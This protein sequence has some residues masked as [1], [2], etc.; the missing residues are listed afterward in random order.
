MFIYFTRKDYSRDEKRPTHRAPARELEFEYVGGIRAKLSPLRCE[1]ICM[2][3]RGGSI[4][5][6]VD[7]SRG[8]LGGITALGFCISAASNGDGLASRSRRR[9][10]RRR[11]WWSAGA[12]ASTDGRRTRSPRWRGRSRND[13]SSPS[14]N[15]GG[16]RDGERLTSSRAW[17]S[18]ADT[19]CCG[20]PRRASPLLRGRDV[21][22]GDARRRQRGP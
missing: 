19:T 9:G 12:R 1:K 3:F 8:G 20:S 10:Q 14:A 18:T 4:G 5:R 22:A 13:G 16:G 2:Y 21:E 15:R 6:R 17:R 11:R 7:A